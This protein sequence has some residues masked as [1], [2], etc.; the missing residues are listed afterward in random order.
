MQAKTGDSVIVE[1]KEKKINGILMPVPEGEKD[2]VIL[3]LESGYNIGIDKKDVKEIKL[4]K[5]YSE[6]KQKTAEVKQNKKLPIISILHTGGTIASKVDYKTGGVIAKFS[7][8]EIIG[9]FPELTKIANIKSRKI[10]SMQSEMMRFV[11]YNL[12]AKEI[13]REIKSGTDGI[14]IT[15]G[16][17][18]MHY[19]SAALRFILED[20]SVPVV[21][22]G[23]Q[24]SSDRG[25]SD[26]GL[27]LISACYFIANSDFADVAIC[28]HENLSDESCLILPALKTRKMHTSRRDAFR[29]INTTA[30][31]R[32]NFNERN[33]SFM[34]KDYDKKDKNKKLKLKLFNEKIKVGLI[35][36]HTNMFA[37]EF[38]AYKNFDGLVIEGTG[39]GHL[40]NE[41]TDEYTKENKKIF[42]S[43]KEM[44]KNGLITVMSSQAIYGRIQ[45]NV[46][47]PMR[48]LQEIGVLGHLSD[49][50][51]ETAFI[52]LAW[53]L[54]NYK[55]EEVKQLITKNLKGEISER[56][57]DKTFLS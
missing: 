19:S 49:M 18:T 3:K 10:A 22:V 9:M 27:N 32:V 20:L 17:D 39:L 4:V 30:I 46:Y 11:H 13:E 36:T 33:I 42:D 45:M 14:I 47:T 38:L 15:H 54:S 7:P 1:T 6:K 56:I 29:P 23:S 41:E 55:K 44:I 43:L 5:S 40:P 31:A 50:T 35:K 8:N 34:K 28:M 25:S 21:L 57:E 2:S 24:R 48:E 12:M 52:K 16:T 26:A 51:P 37:E 53:L